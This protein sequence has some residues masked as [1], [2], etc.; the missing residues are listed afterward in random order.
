MRLATPLEGRTSY[1]VPKQE[2]RATK[3][4]TT[5]HV[6]RTVHEFT[7]DHS[8]GRLQND[9]VRHLYKGIAKV[10]E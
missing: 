9:L 2:I 6:K 3:C 10:L 1:L 7:C 4:F 8:L 5:L